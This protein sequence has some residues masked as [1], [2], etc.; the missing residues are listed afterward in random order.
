MENNNAQFY[1]TNL[2]QTQSMR[3]GRDGDEGTWGEGGGGERETL[4]ACLLY[5]CLCLSACMCALFVCRHPSMCTCVCLTLCACMHA[6]IYYIKLCICITHTQFT[7]IKKTTNDSD[8]SFVPPDII[9]ITQ[10]NTQRTITT[11]K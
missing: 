9:G 3:G 8:F 5:Q 10:S 7:K 4:I 6:Y 2:F 1:D 11:K